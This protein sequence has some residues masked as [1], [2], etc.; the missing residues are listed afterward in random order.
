MEKLDRTF[1]FAIYSLKIWDCQQE[2]SQKI[3]QIDFF[4]IN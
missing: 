2:N 3:T 4:R 1:M